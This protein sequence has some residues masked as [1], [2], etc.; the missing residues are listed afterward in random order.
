MPRRRVGYDTGFELGGRV[1][2]PF[3]P[4]LVRRELS[5]TAECPA[6]R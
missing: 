3:D 1:N 5:A 4:D 2:R 6:V